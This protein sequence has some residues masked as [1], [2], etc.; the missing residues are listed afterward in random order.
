MWYNGSMKARVM[1]A[2]RRYKDRVYETPLV[3]ESYR[4]EKGVPRNHTIANLSGLPPHAIE[5]VRVA[6]REG[7]DA[8]VD[9]V[10][11]QY[12]HSIPVGATHA[13][14]S[15]LHDLGISE[16]LGDYLPAKQ[17]TTVLA[18]I[19]QRVTGEK[20][21]SKRRLCD[22]FSSSGLSLVRQ[23]EKGPGLQTWYRSLNTLEKSRTDIL[24]ALFP[25]GRRRPRLFL[26]DITSSYF[27]GTCCP[28]AHFGYNRDGKKG[29]RQIVIGL[30]TDQEGRPVWVQVFEGNT[31]DQTTVLGQIRLLKDKLKIGELVFVGDRG[32]LT[33]SVIEDIE[34]EFTE[35]KIEYITALKRQEMMELVETQDHPIQLELFDERELCEV[36]EGEVRYVLCHNPNRREQDAATRERLLAKTEQKLRSIYNNV[37]SGRIKKRDV[38]MKRH[39]RWINKWGM[40]RFFE[41]EYGEGQFSYKRKEEEITRYSRL[42]GCYVVKSSVSRDGLNKEAIASSYKSLKYVEQAFRT[43]KTTE[44]ETRPIRHWTPERVKGHVFMC[45]LAYRVIQEARK[46]WAKELERDPVTRECEGDSLREMWAELDRIT[47]GYLRVGD[48]VR[49]QVGRITDQQKHYLEELRAPVR[50]RLGR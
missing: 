34:S 37:Q 23:E 13:V 28:L 8:V 39:F 17:L 26:Y 21:A 36:W 2:R 48:E 29:K 22:D 19:V 45:F 38:I 43:M 7:P 11:V 41:V 27:E 15:L 25:R 46:R 50:I 42:D 10:V 5:A 1:T 40:E 12:S 3:V 24:Q 4:D 33:H 9:G 47:A 30:M 6:L 20:A 31:A 32:M 18:M 49:C 14:L 35:R 16:V 44:L